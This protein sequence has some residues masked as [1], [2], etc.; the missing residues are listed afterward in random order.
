MAEYHFVTTYQIEAPIDQ[1]WQA[2]RDFDHFPTW[3]S[4]S[5]H[6][7]QLESGAAADGVGEKVRFKVRGRLPFTLAFDATIV[8]A[9]PPRTLELRALGELEGVGRW[10]LSQEETATFAK[11]TWDVRTN[12][13][14]MNLAAPLARPI[15]GWNHD[16][17]MRDFGQDLARFLDARLLSVQVGS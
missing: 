8:Q 10:T 9:D 12:K 13:R 7:K 17:V 6:A 2:L 15:F 16:G 1:V 3:S 14:W 5:F 4:G 11:Y